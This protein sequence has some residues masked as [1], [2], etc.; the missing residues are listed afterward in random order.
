M[1]TATVLTGSACFLAAWRLQ[2]RQ[3]RSAGQSA[4][5]GKEEKQRWLLLAIVT[6]VSL[7]SPLWLPY[8]GRSP[9]TRSALDIR[10]CELGFRHGAHSHPDAG[11]TAQKFRRSLLRVRI[12]PAFVVRGAYAAALPISS[13]K[14]VMRKRRRW[15]SERSSSTRCRRNGSFTN[16]EAIR[17]ASISKSR[18]S[19]R[20][21]STFA[22]S[23]R[24]SCFRFA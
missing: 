19:E 7:S 15:L 2:V 10:D 11:F 6:A 9:E 18:S 20:Y 22:G 21:R 3:N 5:S 17:S 8:T 24:R 12:W 16:V 23:W 13:R 1:I 14:Y 4:S